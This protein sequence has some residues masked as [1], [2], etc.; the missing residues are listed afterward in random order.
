MSRALSS[1]LYITRIDRNQ[2][3]KTVAEARK[4]PAAQDGNRFSSIQEKDYFCFG[5]AA[6]VFPSPPALAASASSRAFF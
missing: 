2:T 6:G 4:K 1:F 5:L 3:A